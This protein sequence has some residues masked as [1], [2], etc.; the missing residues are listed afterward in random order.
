VS[1]DDEYP[2][3]MFRRQLP[4]RPTFA[5]TIHK[6]QG[7]TLSNVVIFLN[8]SVF[9]RSQLYVAFSH[10]THPQNLHVVVPTDHQRQ[11]ETTKNIVYNEVLL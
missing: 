8:P 7:Q 2:F 3:V 5:I 1:D 9:T 11:V 6:S 4:V 10:A